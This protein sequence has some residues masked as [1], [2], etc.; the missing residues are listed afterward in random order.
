[1]AQNIK[2]YDKND[3]KFADVSIGNFTFNCRVGGFENT[4]ETVILL[5]G[6]PETSRMWYDLIK[7]LSENNYRVKAINNFFRY[8][9]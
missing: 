3:E 7:I 9:Y 1:M 6:F 4:G 8:V 5:H 2:Y